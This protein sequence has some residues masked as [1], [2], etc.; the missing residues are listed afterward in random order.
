LVLLT[1]NNEKIYSKKCVN[2]CED[3]KTGLKYLLMVSA[4]DGRKMEPPDE[5]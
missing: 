4:L 2:T 3:L 1:G 5:N